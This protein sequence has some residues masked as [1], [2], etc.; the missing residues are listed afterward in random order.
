MSRVS[1]AIGVDWAELVEESKKKPQDI[2]QSSKL[3]RQRWNGVN[4][5]SR[6]G[7]SEKYAGKEIFKKIQNDLR[8]HDESGK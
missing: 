6:I 5:F 3:I 2:E 8:V 1:D 7:I 4:I